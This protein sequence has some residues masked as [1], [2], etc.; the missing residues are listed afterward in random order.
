MIDLSK[1]ADADL[2][3]EVARRRQ[4]K[5][6]VRRGGRKPILQACWWCATQINARQRQRGCPTCGK[7]DRPKR[8]PAPI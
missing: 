4:A 3:A 1:L 2:H 6:K 7:T 8:T 5:R